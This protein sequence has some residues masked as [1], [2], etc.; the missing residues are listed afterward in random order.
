MADRNLSLALRGGIFVT[1]EGM[2]LEVPPSGFDWRA[3]HQGIPN[4]DPLTENTTA[5][6]WPLGTKLIYG[7]RVFRYALAGAGSLVAGNVLQGQA[8]V[9]GHVTEAVDTLSIGAVTVAMTPSATA[10]T[11]NEYQD[12]FFVQDAGASGAGYA[13]KIKSNATSDGSTAFDTVLI[14]PLVVAIPAA[15]TVSMIQNP[16]GEVLQAIVTTPTAKIAG[17]AQAVV[18][19]AKY[20]W[21]QTRGPASVLTEGTVIAG[22]PVTGAAGTAGACGPLTTALVVKEQVIGFCMVAGAD[23]TW[24]TIFLTLE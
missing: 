11:L 24:S 16:W 21:V 4:I 20:G 5:K 13:Y 12:G 14:D 15:G 19:N 10:I 8:P 9:A 23:D 1:R 2:I 17:V 6:Q 7:E 22:N 18:T 3:V